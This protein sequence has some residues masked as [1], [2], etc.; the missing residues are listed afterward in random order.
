[1]L[2]S[3]SPPSPTNSVT[4]ID[5]QKF[6]PN[7]KTTKRVATEKDGGGGFTDG[8]TRKVEELE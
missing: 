6:K 4:M 2:Q 5:K 1:M 8:R 7:K 3:D